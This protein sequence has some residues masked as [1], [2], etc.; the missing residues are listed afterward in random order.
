MPKNRKEQYF[1]MTVL[2]SEEFYSPKNGVRFQVSQ[3]GCD[4]A[5]K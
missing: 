2:D 3:K 4:Q 1:T 5:E